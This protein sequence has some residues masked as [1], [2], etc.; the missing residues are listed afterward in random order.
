MSWL[1]VREGMQSPEL[2]VSPKP[3][4]AGSNSARYQ[5]FRRGPFGCTSVLRSVYVRYRTGGRLPAWC[6]WQWSVRPGRIF[7]SGFSNEVGGNGNNRGSV[8]IETSQQRNAVEA[9]K[10]GDLAICG[11]WPPTVPTSRRLVTPAMS[12]ARALR[13]VASPRSMHDALALDHY[14]AR[15]LQLTVLAIEQV[16]NGADRENAA[17]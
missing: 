9:Q 8:D 15:G 3:P 4:F 6:R 11:S 5:R 13:R 2:L 17:A 14:D 7:R 10:S 16:C 12:N 1:A